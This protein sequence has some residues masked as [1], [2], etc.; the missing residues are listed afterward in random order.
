VILTNSIVGPNVSIEQGSAITGSVV[1]NSILRGHTRVQ[2]CVMDNCMIGERAHVKG[3]A[4]DLSL[5][6]DST[7]G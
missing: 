7:L 6:D 3:S 5:S 4:L 2:D 1:R